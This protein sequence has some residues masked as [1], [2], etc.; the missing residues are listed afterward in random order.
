MH[1]ILEDLYDLCE[2]LEKDLAKTNEKLRMAGGELSGSDLEYVDKLTHSLKSIKTTMAMIEAA[3]DGFSYEGSSYAGRGGGGGNRG[4]GG[5]RSREGGMSGARGRTGNVRRDSMGRYS[6]GGSSRE[7]GYSGRR[8][9]SR[10]GGMSYD[11]ARDELMEHIDELAE[12]AK[13]EETK[14]MIQKFKRELK[15]A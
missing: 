6:R 5:G 10:E 7:G 2:V 13:D 12:M 9:Y 3:D 4:G 1:D 8:G 14:A 15:D 11:G